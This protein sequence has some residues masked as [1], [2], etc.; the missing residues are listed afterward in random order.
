MNVNSWGPPTKPDQ[1]GCQSEDSKNMAIIMAK[2]PVVFVHIMENLRHTASC[3]ADVGMVDKYPHG[4][5]LKIPSGKRL[6]F[7]NWKIA[8]FNG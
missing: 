7:A 5:R 1:Q 6:Q 3:T 2:N 4:K 8:I